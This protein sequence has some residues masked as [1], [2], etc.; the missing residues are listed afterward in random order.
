MI[1]GDHP[2]TARA[3]A[4]EVGLLSPEGRVVEGVDLPDDER[5]SAS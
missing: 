3:V 1:T 4:D 2:S 5:P